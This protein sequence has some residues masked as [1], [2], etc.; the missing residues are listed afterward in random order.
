MCSNEA[1]GNGEDVVLEGAISVEAVLRSNSRVVREIRFSRVRDDRRL[2]KIKGLA[3]DK[4]VECC[5]V[6]SDAIDELVTGSSHGG[7]VAVVGGRRYVSMEKLVPEDHPAFVVMLDGVEDPFS[8][9]HAVRAIYA[10]GADGLVVRSRNWNQAAG[11]VAR[12]SAGATE[13]M[14]TAVVESPAEAASF[15]E[16][17]GLAVGVAGKKKGAMDLHECDMT[18][19]LFLL[20]GGERRGVQRSFVNEADMVISVPYGR[21]FRQSLDTVSAAAVVAFEVLRQR[22]NSTRVD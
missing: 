17:R 22:T 15:F 8:Y 20:L 13:M 9:G 5:A 19:P 16:K 18:G 14:A 10:A 6:S 7:V 21:R 1:E 11:V 2:Q 12:A 4:G 3:R